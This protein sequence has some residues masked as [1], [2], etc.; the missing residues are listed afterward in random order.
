MSVPQLII[1]FITCK[2][3]TIY[4]FSY[5]TGLIAKLKK[6]IHMKYLKMFKNFLKMKASL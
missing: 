4:V 5:F 1:C 3:E 6:K 2:M